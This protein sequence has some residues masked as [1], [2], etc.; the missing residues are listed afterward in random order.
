MSIPVEDYIPWQHMSF[1]FSVLGSKLLSY[2]SD[3]IPCG[4]L[5]DGF[6]SNCFIP[7]FLCSQGWNVHCILAPGV[8]DVVGSCFVHKSLREFNL[9]VDKK[10]KSKLKQQTLFLNWPD[11]SGLDMQ[12]L[13]EFNP[14]YLVILFD[15]FNS[16]SAALKDFLIQKSDWIENK[17][18][19]KFKLVKQ[20]ERRCGTLDGLE[21]K[22][23]FLIFR[24]SVLCGPSSVREICKPVLLFF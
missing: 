15:D 10:T 1:G 19:I 23:E 12:L 16:G 22:V 18:H 6:C 14:D 20:L 7:N 2:I 21:R 24:K 5:I 8:S 4:I 13:L 17:T 3:T 11:A 9:H